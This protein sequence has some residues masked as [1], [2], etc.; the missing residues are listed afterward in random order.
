MTELTT[1]GRQWIVDLVRDQ[2][3]PKPSDYRPGDTWDD[4]AEAIA[5]AILAQLPLLAA[6]AIK[7]EKQLSQAIGWSLAKADSCRKLGELADSRDAQAAESRKNPRTAD[8]V[9][10]MYLDPLL[11]FR[12]G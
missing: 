3:D 8:E 2:F 10:D 7:R 5:D 1:P 6:E 4:G 11:F 12:L 9:P